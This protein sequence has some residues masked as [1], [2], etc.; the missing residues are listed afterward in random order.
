MT[1]F[2]IDL[3][4]FGFYPVNGGANLMLAPVGRRAGRAPLDGAL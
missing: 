1:F 4:T 2:T 3:F